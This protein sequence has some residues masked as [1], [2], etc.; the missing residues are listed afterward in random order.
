MCK[1]F[2]IL[3]E[4]IKKICYNQYTFAFLSHGVLCARGIPWVRNIFLKGKQLKP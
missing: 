1:I 2:K 3:I 4:K